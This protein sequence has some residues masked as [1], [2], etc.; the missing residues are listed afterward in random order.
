MASIIRIKRSEVAG[1]PSVLAAGELAYSALPDNGS[2]GGDRLYIGIGTETTGDAVN[3]YVIGGK[4]FT[5]RL[6]HTAGTLTANSAIVVDGN[7]KIDNLLVDNL[8]LNGNT[9]STTDTNGNLILAPNGTGL[10]SIASAYTLPRADGTVGQALIT[11]GSGTV[12]FATISTTLNIAG[13]TGTDAVSL[14]TDTLTFTGGDGI[15]SAV[16]N[17]AVSF[18][19]D[20]SIARRADTHY[21]GTTAVTLNRASANLALT[22]I[23]S[24]AFAGSTSGT[25]TLTPTAIA[26]TNTITLPAL[27]GT[28]A[29][30]NQKL[31]V[32]AAT[33]SAELAGVISDETGTGSLVFATAPTFTTSIDGGATFGAFGSSTALTLGFTGTAANTTN[34]ATGATATGTTKTVNIGT[35]GAAGSTTNVNLGSASGGIV[36]VNSALTVTGDLTVNG[37]ITTV[38]STTLTVDDKN[39]ELGSVAIPSN[40]TADGG[41]ITLKGTTDKTF[42]W[43]NAT[44]AWTSSEDLNLLTGKVYEINGTTVLSATTL[45][46]GV[47][48]SSLTSVGT[49]T[50]GTWQGTVVGPTY[51]GTGLSTYSTGDLLYASAS[52]TLAKRAI[53]TEGKVLQVSAGGLP[54]WG[55]LDGGTY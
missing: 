43:V 47:T 20:A 51:G 49:I 5:D 16:T 3:H 2:N 52:N 38:N 9:L 30:T 27:T 23:L 15:T 10:V 6:D 25:I 7:S 37:T 35:G 41:G 29:L 46:S 19:T 21:I 31:N 55:D 17:N 18:V 14:I 13:D 33:T 4:F 12:S 48:T 26:G 50:T 39:I 32:F 8:Q 1:N 34:I 53:G 54:I 24:T 11:N 40:A 22:G 45:G 42:N 36:T 28:V 44:A